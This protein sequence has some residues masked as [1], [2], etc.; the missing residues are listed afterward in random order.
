MKTT[1]LLLKD[2]A[3]IES[4]PFVDSRGLFA[5]FYCKQELNDVCNG[6]EIVSINFSKTIKKGTIRGLHFQYHP[7]CEIKFARCIRGSV[8]DVI[9]DIRKDSATFLQWIGIELSTDNMKMVEIPEGFAHGFQTLEDNVE[10]LYLHTAHYAPGFEDGIHYRDPAL[11]ITWPL[12]VIDISEKDQSH[13]FINS[14]F[15]GVKL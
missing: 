15:H 2:A 14:N 13:K 5:R 6:R 12:E 1:K 7:H 11:N 9:V 3:L 8:Y 10:M 4:E